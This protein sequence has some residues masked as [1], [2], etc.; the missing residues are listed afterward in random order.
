MAEIKVGEVRRVT[1]EDNQFFGRNG[2]IVEVRGVG[3][4]REFRLTFNPWPLSDWFYA[5][6]LTYVPDN[7]IPVMP[8]DLQLAPAQPATAD[9]NRE[10]GWP[11]RDLD[12]L[13]FSAMGVKQPATADAGADGF[14]PYLM[15]GTRLELLEAFYKFM[16]DMDAI[17]ELKNELESAGE[18]ESWGLLSALEYTLRK[19]S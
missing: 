12:E 18:M 11:Q 14:D 2:K 19:T 16:V 5:F 1:K 13:G 3:G 4:S 7:E 10:T 8:A 6:E 15:N 17:H 9:A